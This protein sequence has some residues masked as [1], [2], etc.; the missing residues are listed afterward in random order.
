MFKVAARTILELGAELISSDA[1]AIYELVKNGVDAQSKNGV[2]VE[3]SISI[4]HSDYIDLS[5]RVEDALRLSKEER[6]STETKKRTLGELKQQIIQKI[7][8]TAPSIVRRNITARIDETGTLAQLSDDLRELYRLYNWVEVRDTGCGM[9]IEDLVNSY[10]VIGTPSRRRTLD[11]NISSA[12][13]KPTFLGEKGVGRL[14]AMRLGSQFVI[15]TATVEDRYFNVLNIDWS[16]FEDLDKMVEDV[17]I[18]PQRG[19]KKL[20][21]DYSGT[22]IRVSDLG[23]SWSLNTIKEVATWQLARITDPFART[24]RRLRIEIIFN[25]DRVEIP[26]MEQPLLDLAHARVNGTYSI[27]DGKPSL[28]INLWCGDLGI[29]N[30]PEERRIFLEKVDL[31]SITRGADNEIAASALTTAGPFSFELYWYN[32]QRIKSVDAFGDR[33]RILNLLQQWSGIMLFRDGYRVFPYGDDDDDWLALDRR[34]LASSGYKLNKQQ[35]VGRVQ[36]SRIRNS[37]LIDQTNREGLKDCDEKSVLLEVMQ[38]VIQSRLR[39]FLDEVIRKHRSFELDYETSERQV[40][41]LRGRALTSIQALEKRHSE[42]LPVL[43]QLT[44]I[45]EEMNDYFLK[46]KEK[47]EQVEDERDRMVQLAGIGLMLEIVAHELARSTEHTIQVLNNAKPELVSQ[48]L[49]ALFKSL[50]DEMITMNKRLRVL[51]PL[52]VSGRQRRETFDLCELV[53]EVIAG[54]AAQFKRHNVRVSLK[55]SPA[56]S[57]VMVTGVRGMFIQI[58]ENLIQNSI[59]W[60]ALKRQDESDYK[61]SITILLGPIPMLMQFSDNGPGIQAS[62]QDEVFKAFFSTKGKSRRQGLGLYIARDCAEHNGASLYLS[63]DS[64]VSSGRLNTFILEMQESK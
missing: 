60:M 42:E 63:P 58:L 59:Y 56:S 54:R 53:Q 12:E 8:S 25:D 14:S 19:E 45:I 64:S 10:L 36:I 11:E 4:R 32:R 9:T 1:V 35:F 62:L 51:D 38:F 5:E 30:P 23:T 6:W 55:T 57:K 44:S 26:R 15:T 43:H 16:Q 34:A 39:Q 20:P 37:R 40:R 61:P 2:T 24:K 50:R 21:V 52:S 41:T 29:G 31:R 48:E 27:K 47:A 28:E 22:V 46:A 17:T 49:S 3:F 33:K 7:Q 18:A 13:S